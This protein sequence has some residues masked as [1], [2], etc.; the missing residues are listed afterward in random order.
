MLSLHIA[1]LAEFTGGFGRGLIRGVSRYTREHGHWRLFVPM[2]DATDPVPLR[3]W[4]GDGL[5]AKARSAAVAELLADLAVPRVI[6]SGW[7][8]EN[9]TAAPMVTLRTYDKPA[10]ARLAVDHFRGRGFDHLAFC[11]FPGGP[12]DFGRYLPFAHACDDAGLRLEQYQAPASIQSSDHAAQQ[13]HLADWLAALPHPV[14]VWAVNDLRGQHVLQACRIAGLMVPDDVAV[15]G[16]GNDE[17]LCEVCDPPLS[18]IAIAQE[19]IGY[20]AAA[21]LDQLMWGQPVQGPP[22]PPPLGVVTRQSTDTVAVADPDVAAAVH[23]IR[24]HAA[25]PISV[26]Q[27]LDHVHAS[28][29]TLDRRFRESLGRTVHEQIEQAH[30]QRAQELLRGTNLKMEQVAARSGY[31]NARRLAEAFRRVLGQPPSAYRSAA[32]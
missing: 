21:V 31:Q 11:G 10:E 18:S 29:S 14:G 25:D 17:L 9:R 16:H 7:R 30:L 26:E 8:T 19:G 2:G 15:L 20:D 22:P 12:L 23:F 13:R 24:D 1:V 28:R 5:I 6:V 3:G 4:R 32:R 27:V